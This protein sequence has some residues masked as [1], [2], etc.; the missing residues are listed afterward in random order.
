MTHSLVS[1]SRTKSHITKGVN[2]AL[3][4][5][6][7][8]RVFDFEGELP[9]TW[10]FLH[11]LA[12]KVKGGKTKTFSYFVYGPTSVEVQRKV[13]DIGDGLVSDGYNIVKSGKLSLDDVQKLQTS[14]A[15]ASELLAMQN[16]LL[17]ML[18]DEHI[19]GP[20]FPTNAD[21]SRPN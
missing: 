9:G 13:R 6:S 2:M 16:G 18:R 14:L 17:R 20:L 5:S 1:K 19:A 15:E 11:I 3:A 10:A 4:I 12:K 8:V 7:T 21:E